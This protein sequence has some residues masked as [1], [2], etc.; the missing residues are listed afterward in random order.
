MLSCFGK[1]TVLLPSFSVANVLK[2]NV[3]LHRSDFSIA[4]CTYSSMMEVAGLGVVTENA[5]PSSN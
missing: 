2:I 4:Y 5:E 1:P 3:P